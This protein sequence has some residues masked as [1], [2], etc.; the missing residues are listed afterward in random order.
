MLSTCPKCGSLFDKD[1]PWKKVCLS[2]WQKTKRAEAKEPYRPGAELERLR[3]ENQNLRAQ[4]FYKPPTGIE[5][6]MLRRL[7]QLAH[8]DKHGNSQ[9]ATIATKWLLTQRKAA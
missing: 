6:E 1:E 2:C 4:L 9:A 5:P 7:I 8:P 3:A